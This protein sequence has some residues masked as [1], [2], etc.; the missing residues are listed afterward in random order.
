MKR[1]MP[2]LL[3]AG[4]G[5]HLPKQT[6]GNPAPHGVRK[7]ELLPP[8]GAYTLQRKSKMFSLHERK[9]SLIYLGLSHTPFNTRLFLSISSL[10]A[11]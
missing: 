9:R 1:R 10:S 5:S 8:K 2:G 4:D 3:K 6:P 11:S 7:S